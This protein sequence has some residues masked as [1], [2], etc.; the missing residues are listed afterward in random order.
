MTTFEHVQDKNANYAQKILNNQ[1]A[2]ESGECEDSKP[3]GMLNGS[4]QSLALPLIFSGMVVI[5]KVQ[6]IFVR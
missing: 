5:Y 1:R 3:V 6:K 2:S 4:Y